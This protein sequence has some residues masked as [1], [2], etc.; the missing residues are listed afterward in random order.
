MATQMAETP[1]LLGK[2]AESV[3]KQIE[4][5]PSTTQVEAYLSQLKKQFQGIT[6]RRG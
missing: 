1:T 3:L 6:V 2:D 5:A 4:Q